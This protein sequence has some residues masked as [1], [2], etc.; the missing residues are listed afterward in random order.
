MPLPV[1]PRRPRDDRRAGRPVPAGR[2]GAVPAR[3]QRLLRDVPRPG[4]DGAAVPQR[5]H[6]AHGLR[7]APRRP[8]SV[9]ERP[10][11]RL[12]R[13]GIPSTSSISARSSR[14]TS[15]AAPSSPGCTRTRTQDR[16]RSR[17]GTF[18]T[19]SCRGLP[20]LR[21]VTFEF[22]DSYYGALGPGGVRAQLERAREVFLAPSSTPMTLPAFQQALCE[23][24]ASPDLCLEVRAGT[25]GLPRSLRPLT[26]GTR[27]PARHRVAARACRR[28]AR[29]TARIA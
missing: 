9:R 7:R 21:A 22:H 19:T 24:I 20:N 29:C 18:S 1:R 14:P 23:L 28:T 4:D 17:C 15:R 16:V 3:E 27:S 11:P 12:R 2:V 5:D 10:E 25:R 13:Q 26:A 6:T 8:Q